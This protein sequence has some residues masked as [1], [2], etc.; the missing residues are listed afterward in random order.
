MGQN[1]TI[2]PVGPGPN[3]PAPRSFFEQ[4][5]LL[6]ETGVVA[7]D[8]QLFNPPIIGIHGNNPNDWRRGGVRINPASWADAVFVMMNRYGIAAV[9]GQAVLH[10]LS[11]NITLLGKIVFGDRSPDPPEPTI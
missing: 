11:Y 5:W 2:T 9:Y 1:W 10:R 6:V 3:E 8:E 7:T 4:K